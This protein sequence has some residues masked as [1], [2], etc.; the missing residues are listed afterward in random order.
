MD[1]Q[2]SQNAVS[3]HANAGGGTGQV[4]FTPEQQAIIDR[5]AAE[6][7]RRGGESA[8]RELLESLGVKSVDELKSVFAD[9]NKLRELQKT[10]LQRAQEE[11]RRA[12]EERDAIKRER[13]AVLARAQQKLMRAT[14][15]AEAMKIFDESELRSVWL[16]IKEDPELFN[17]IKPRA[18]SED[19][20]DGVTHAVEA[21]AKRHPRWLKSTGAPANTNAMARGKA[22][23]DVSEIMKA[24]RTQYGGARL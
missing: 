23:V 19:E 24:K 15:M 21:V 2:M 6:R 18:D 17:L 5:I 3:E 11:A 1:G 20:F 8:V 16:E 12:Q 10:E 7:A 9:A 22:G 4:T 14:V 13:D